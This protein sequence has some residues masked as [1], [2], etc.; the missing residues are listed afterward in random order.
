M[1]KKLLVLFTTFVLFHSLPFKWVA[2]RS[3]GNLLVAT[4]WASDVM[5]LEEIEVTEYP[6]NKL[7]PQ[8]S[9][10]TTTLTLEDK[11]NGTWGWAEVGQTLKFS[12]PIQISDN[13]PG[14]FIADA[15]GGYL[16]NETEL[17]RSY[18]AQLRLEIKGDVWHFSPE[19]RV[20]D[21]TTKVG[22]LSGTNNI[23][24]HLNAKCSFEKSWWVDDEAVFGFTV[25]TLL[26]DV[27]WQSFT[28]RL[29]YRKGSAQ[30]PFVL[31]TPRT[32]SGSG[33]VTSNPTGIDCGSDCSESFT[34]G[35]SVTITA[36]PFPGSTFAGWT[37]GGCSGTGSCRVVMNSD[38]TVGA[39][40]TS[41]GSTAMTQVLSLLLKPKIQPRL[42]CG[43]GK[44][45]DCAHV[46]VDEETAMSYIGDSIC[47]DGSTGFDLRCEAF[48]YDDFDCWIFK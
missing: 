26:A 41:T 24:L 2:Y 25:T 47:D 21:D 34:A 44:V 33:T 30:G 35:S 40:F 18:L 36:T 22:D 7:P 3:H 9:V 45:Y 17:Y 5:V 12:Y 43:E 4:T 8:L 28:L 42:W 19:C 48:R 10:G 11:Q 23:S 16:W 6:G 1:F 14:E 32:G 27:I 29:K 15:F 13:A 37:G 39:I 38:L 46:C 20:K 31:F